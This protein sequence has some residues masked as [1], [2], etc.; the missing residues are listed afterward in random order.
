MLL[1][2]GNALGISRYLNLMQRY[3]DLVEIANRSKLR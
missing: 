3:A 1:T 2:L